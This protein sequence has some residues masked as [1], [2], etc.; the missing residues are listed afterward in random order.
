MRLLVITQKVD[1]DDPILGFFHRWIEEFAKNCKS[2]VVICLGKGK[3]NLPNNVKVLS[4]GKPAQGWSASGRE[5]VYQK[6]LA[7]LNFYRY[8]WSE[9]KNYENVF[10]HMNQEYVLLGGLIWKLLGKKI[11]LWRNHLKGTFL[12]LLSVWLANTAFCTSPQSYTA[13]FKKTKLMP[14]GIDTDF[15]T[16]DVAIIK[17]P[18]SI[19]FLGRISPVKNVDIFIDSLIALRQNNF[20]FTTTIAGGAFSVDQTYEQELR[21]KVQMTDLTDQVKFIGPVT[22]EQARQLYREHELYVNLTPAGSM[23]KTIFEALACN[24]PA[25]VCNTDLFKILG[26]NLAVNNLSPQAI[27]GQINQF[28]SKPD[29]IDFRSKIIN[30]HSLKALVNSLLTIMIKV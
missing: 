27:A 14:V 25:L 22:Q 16:P 24:L 18:H 5:K 29:T 6:F 23:D 10:V 3:Y 4:L 12:T 15:F 13:R 17:K 8:I 28:W 26:A 9:R 1:R 20:N 7:F 30:N 2:V 19:L 11:Y 21:K